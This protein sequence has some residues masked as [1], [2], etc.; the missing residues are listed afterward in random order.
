MSAILEA[1]AQ[2]AVCRP[3]AP[4]LTGSD[5]ALSYRNLT[6]AVAAQA[7][8][9]GASPPRCLALALDN[10]PAWVVAD[11]AAVARGIPVVP[12]PGFFSQNQLRHALRDAGAEVLL[13]DRPAFFHALLEAAGIAHRDGGA[14]LIAGRLCHTLWL[15]G[16]ASGGALPGAA[17]ITY[18]SGTTGE[19]K[20]MCLAQATLEAVAASVVRAAGFIRNDRHLS[21]LPLSTLLEN[22]AGVYAPLLA[23]AGCHLP[24]LAEAGM[25][26]ASAL[27]VARMVNVLTGRCASTTILLPQMLQALVEVIESGVAAAPA[28]RFAA[29]GGARVSP[30]LLERAARAGLAVYQGY[31]LSECGSVVAM[32]TEAANRPGSVG[33]PLPH[34]RLTVSPSGEIQVGGATMLGYCGS[35]FRHS[36]PIATGDLGFLDTQGCLYLTGRRKNVFITSFGRN[37]SP[38]WVEAELTACPGIRQA[39]VFGEAR[40]W[41]VALIVS[42]LA[43]SEAGRAALDQA[44]ARANRELPDYAQVRRWIAADAPF[45]AHNGLATPRPALPAS[46]LRGLPGA[47]R[48]ALPGDGGM[49]R[50]QG[51]AKRGAG[52]PRSGDATVKPAKGAP[53][54]GPT[55]ASGVRSPLRVAPLPPPGAPHFV[56][57]RPAAH[58]A[59]R[60][61]TGDERRQC[62]SEAAA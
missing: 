9:F 61:H 26:G 53:N 11:L 62:G 14:H 52:V 57:M 22:V 15:S 47:H 59:R 40:P 60:R 5:A 38:E 25:M 10:S 33:R 36:G 1:L 16:T 6:C 29:V 32:N 23:G 19:P 20:G 35:T 37:V 12:L 17:K 55:R 39:A 2:H 28:L 42:P 8:T 30:R 13:T 43:E 50:K 45:A 44:L 46:H 58:A 4:A 48:S 24:P 49:S 27:D 7:Q 21:L 3:Q 34:L 18:T 56:G 31:G 51:P 54:A 41:N